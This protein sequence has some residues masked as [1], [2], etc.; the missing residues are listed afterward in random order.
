MGNE[1]N[2]KLNVVLGALEDELRQIKS[3]KEQVGIAVSAN[4]EL[5]ANLDRLIGSSKELV[6][7]SNDQTRNAVEALSKE[8]AGLSAR[9]KEIESAA[10]CG[11]E[12]IRDQAAIAQAALEET[13]NRAVGTMASEA[14]ASQDKAAAAIDALREQAERMEKRTEAAEAASAETAEAGKH[15]ASDAQAMLEKTAGSAI[16]R[17]S[18]KIAEFTKEGITSVGNDLQEAKSDMERAI[19]SLDASTSSVGEARD[20]LVEAHE[21]ALS[22]NQRQ[23]AE[24]RALLEET[25]RRLIEID[26]RIETLKDIDID[27]LVSELKELKDIEASNTAALKKQLTSVTVMVAACIVICLAALAKLLIA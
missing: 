15:Q 25:Q 22:E 14:E 7:E 9:A 17:V 16:E 5:S 20:E 18:L 1:S 23:S 8:V 19:E 6:R 13:A 3:A 24:T 11:A 12:T 27:S 10:S 4:S 21:K 2:A 26:A